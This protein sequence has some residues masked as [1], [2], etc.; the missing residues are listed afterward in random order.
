MSLQ[1]SFITTALIGSLVFIGGCSTL[2]STWKSTKAFYG[3]YINP[4]AQIGYEDKG[5]LN[6]AET[7]LASRMV[8]IDIQATSCG[9]CV[10]WL[11]IRRLGQK[12]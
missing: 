1:S 9:A 5:V 6:D 3:E 2:D 4:P 11:R 8:G 10:V 7:M 12:C